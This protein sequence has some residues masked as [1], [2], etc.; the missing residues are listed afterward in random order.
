[1]R[2]S[3][4]VLAGVAL[5]LS[6]AASA[7]PSTTVVPSG[8]A[9]VRGGAHA[10]VNYGSSPQLRVKDSADDSFTRV[11]LLRFDFSGV[12]RA[13]VTRATLRLYCEDRP[14]AD[15][16]P[17]VVHQAARWSEATTT[18]ATRPA[19][20]GGALDE[21]AVTTCDRWYSLDV[22]GPVR[23]E[24]GRWLSFALT[25]ESDVNRLVTFSSREGA[26][27]PEL[28]LSYGDDAPDFVALA[29]AYADAM[30]ADGR[31]RY[32]PTPSP[33]FATMLDR[34]TMALIPNV[35]SAVPT[36]TN[37]HGI[38]ETD[39]SW[40][41]ANL[42]DDHE[43]HALLYALSDDTGDPSYAA[44]A[45]ASLGWYAQNTAFPTGLIPWGEHAGWRLDT[46]AATR[47]ASAWGDLKHELQLGMTWLWP[48]LFEQAPD[49]MIAYARGLWEEH[50][51]DKD[52]VLWA[53]QTRLDGAYADRGWIFARTAGHM[54]SV[55]AHAYQ[56][57]GDPAVRAEM[58]GYIDAVADAHNGRRNPQSDAVTQWWKPPKNGQPGGEVGHATSNDLQGVIDAQRALDLGV[59]PEPTAARLR[60]WVARS[61]AT[62]HAVSHPFGRGAVGFYN[63]VDLA[64]LEPLDDPSGE[65]G[66]EPWCSAYGRIGPVVTPAVNVLTRYQQ[67]GD[68]RFLQLA[69]AAADWYRGRTPECDVA[70]RDA[71]HPLPL[72]PGPVAAAIELFLGV[73][74]ATGDGAYL[75]EAERLGRFA[76]ATF[77]DDVSALPRVWAPGHPSGYDHYEGQTGGPALMLA[78]YRLGTAA[79]GTAASVAAPPLAQA[80][81]D[82]ELTLAVAPNP[83]PGPATVT[84]HLPRAADVRVE[85][86]DALG[87]RV[88]TLA[89]GPLEAGLHRAGVDPALPAGVYFV[90]LQ[91]QAGAGAGPA[92]AGWGHVEVQTRTLTVVR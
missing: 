37:V 56:A 28:V 5:L 83:T 71:P 30:V 67:S 63:R 51:Y 59:L 43:L 15:P 2:S 22:S 39:R 10:D 74:D 18:Y 66:G 46:D 44:A 6:V 16:A 29:R 20:M 25:Q 53:H 72:W 58:L 23:G 34:E 70:V 87:R 75:A 88:A 90:R 60:D 3:S 68:A 47:H 85:V 33:L 54:V 50:V 21:V 86:V 73:Y 61:T 41:A 40:N 49:A 52:A 65:G 9:Y 84:F 82:A 38:R 27:P 11:G 78:L 8:D 32:G 35:K 89:Q 24:S 64:T 17:V 13:A 91:A 62:F 31:D 80:R 69:R 57:S 81:A 55:W 19:L 14:N 77:L 42:D 26:R 48:H 45:D 12:D 4:R 79:S 76:A 1:M 36:E 92:G 7:Q